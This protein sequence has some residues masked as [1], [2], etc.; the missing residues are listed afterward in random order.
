L[1]TVI[2]IPLTS[3]I[4]PYSFRVSCIVDNKEGAIAVDQI[5]TIDKTRIKALLGHLSDKDINKLRQ[6]LYI[7][8]CE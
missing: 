7:M 3:T 8:L 1:K 2:V 4:K 5:R 6:A